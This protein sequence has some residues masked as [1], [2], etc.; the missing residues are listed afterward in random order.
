MTT[1]I[2]TRIFSDIDATFAKNPVTNDVSKVYD[3]IS[4]KR[5]LKSLIFSNHYDHPFHPEIYS[6]IQELLFQNYTQDIGNILETLITELITNY[7]PRVRIISIDV[8]TNEE[9]HT[10]DASLY[11][12][13]INN[14]NPITYTVALQR[15]R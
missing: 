4:V 13:I 8:S 14:P 6:P 11:F 5:S 3:E 12:Y 15:L 1:K 2:K 7:E 9:Q 10:L